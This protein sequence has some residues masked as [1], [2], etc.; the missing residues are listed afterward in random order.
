MR[1]EIGLALLLVV[2]PADRL[3]VSVYQERHSLLE[4]HV[5]EFDYGP[6]RWQ[7]LDRAREVGAFAEDFGPVHYVLGHKITKASP[8]EGLSRLH[9]SNLGEKSLEACDEGKVPLPG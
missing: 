4:S 9:P 7:H 1:G 3:A 5:H 6:G 8:A 2:W